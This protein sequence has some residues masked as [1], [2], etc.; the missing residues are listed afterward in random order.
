MT[1]RETAPKS[2]F[3]SF[4]FLLRDK[5]LQVT[6]REWLMFTEALSKCLVAADLYRFYAI[7]R[8]T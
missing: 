6:T 4:F 8:A 2:L 3:L 7:A 5:G 1:S